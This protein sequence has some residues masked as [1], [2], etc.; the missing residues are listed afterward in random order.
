MGEGERGKGWEKSL[1][2]KVSWKNGIGGGE[3]GARD[4]KIKEGEEFRV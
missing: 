3:W 4:R 1:H 2:G